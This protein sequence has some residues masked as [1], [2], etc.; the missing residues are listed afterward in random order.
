MPLRDAPHRPLRLATAGVFF[1]GIDTRKA[2]DATWEG[3]ARHGAARRLA[4]GLYSRT[5][6]HDAHAS[7]IHSD[8]GTPR[9]ISGAEASNAK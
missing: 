7:R 1:R 3:G 4:S 5:L 2:G 9:H 8:P 6:R